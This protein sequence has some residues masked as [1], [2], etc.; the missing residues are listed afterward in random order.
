M[1]EMLAREHNPAIGLA[2]SRVE[3]F[4]GKYQQAGLF[5]N[6]KA[7]YHATE[8]GNLGTAGQQGGFVSQRFIT[9][10]KLKL[11][12]HIATHEIELAGLNSNTE[13][14]RVLNDVRTRFHE[15]LIAQ[16]RIVL[17]AELFR[18]GE[19]S[20]AASKD[21]VAGRQLSPNGLLQSL[22]LKDS[23]EILLETA[24]NDHKAAWRQLAAVVGIEDLDRMRV[25]GDPEAG[26]VQFSWDERLQQLLV[27]SPELAT[28]QSAVGVARA[29]LTRAGREWIPDIDVMVST[30]H[31]NV[32]GDNVVNV[33]AGIPI[34]IFDRNQG[35][36]YRAEAEI[37][38]AMH[39][40][41]RIELG[42]QERLAAEFRRYENARVRFTR[43]KER[44]VP[45]ARKSLDIV[46]KAYAEGQLD[47]LELLTSQSTFART[48]L[49][50]LDAL[51][52]LK[53]SQVALEGQLVTGSLNGAEKSRLDLSRRRPLRY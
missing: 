17:T 43:H 27:A 19:A 45:N 18:I 11:D 36:V 23:S 24:R 34:P 1:L 26:L 49:D 53:V 2:Q 14:Q 21:L 5:P 29:R 48:N 12:Q 8:I 4:R 41:R 44:I 9:G 32:T 31:H 38:A 22:I 52:E 42:L 7:G 15:V 6:P 3:S 47:Y 51:R 33:Q 16:Q 10:S 46:Q 39:R 40:V 25:E 35:N 28:A 20:V 13:V 30:R 50:M 37:V